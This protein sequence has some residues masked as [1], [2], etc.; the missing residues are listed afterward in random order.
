VEG[1]AGGWLYEG[2]DVPPAVLFE[3]VDYALAIQQ[4]AGERERE[5][6]VAALP[7]RIAG[8]IPRS[9]NARADTYEI[10]RTCLDYPGGLQALLAALDGFAGE[11]LA[12]GEFKQAVVRLLY[13][14]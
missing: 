2:R 4:M 10:I 11:S 14:G 9:F 8:M 1:R 5:R 3:L 13:G 6:V 12:F 7:V